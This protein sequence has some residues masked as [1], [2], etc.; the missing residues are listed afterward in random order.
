MNL[1]SREAGKYLKKIMANIFA[2]L[3]K[4]D[5]QDDQSIPSR[6]NT[7]ETTP[8]LIITKFLELSKADLKRD[9]RQNPTIYRGDKM[10][11]RWTAHQKRCNP[12]D[13]GGVSLKHGK[14]KS[15]NL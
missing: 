15:F 2:S 11:S 8:M 12:E 9:Q 14:K 4:T 13:D 1:S 7:K 6:R 10:T 3:M 5:F